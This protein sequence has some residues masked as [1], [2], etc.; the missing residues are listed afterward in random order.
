MKMALLFIFSLLILGCSKKDEG[1]DQKY[2]VEEVNKILTDAGAIPDKKVTSID[3][4]DYAVG[5]GR[6]TSKAME[7]QRLSFL[8]IEFETE[9]QA[10][11]EAVRLNQY[12]SRNWLFDRTEG[13]PILE[14]FVI[15]NFKAIS[16]NRSFQR[17]P[18]AHAAPAHGE[19][20]GEGHEAAPAAH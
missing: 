15:L 5:V 14:D 4:S 6:T 9:T 2:T 11:S 1:K 12:Y 18:K 7:Y 3:F 13:E 17:K 10:K 20:H 19:A 8:A 16:P